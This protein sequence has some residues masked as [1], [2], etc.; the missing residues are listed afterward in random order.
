[1]V[2]NVFAVMVSLKLI[3]IVASVLRLM[4]LFAG[5]VSVIVGGVVSPPA[6]CTVTLMFLLTA[7]PEAS[8]A[9]TLR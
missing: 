6:L 8:V 4:L 2:V 5:I 3:L 9:L 7:L 1:M